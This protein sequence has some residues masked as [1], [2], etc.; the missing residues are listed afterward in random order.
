MRQ[1]TRARLGSPAARIAVAGTVIVLLV[2]GALGVTIWRFGASIN[3]YDQAITSVDT[4]TAVGATRTSAFDVSEAV[5]GDLIAPGDDPIA[6]A[7]EARSQ[8]IAHLD[9][10]DSSDAASTQ[11][12][13]AIASAKISAT[14]LD[15]EIRDLAAARGPSAARRTV[16]SIRSAL[17]A[18]D[19]QLD[20]ITAAEETQAAGARSSAHATGDS[21]RLVGIIVGALAVLAVMALVAYA[22]RLVTRLLTRIR[23]TSDGLAHASSE[24]RAATAVGAAATT[25]QSAAIAEVAVTLEEL[26]VS[27]A[28]IA[29]NARSTATEALETGQRSQQIGQVLELI[30]GVAEQTNLLALNA[31]IE[32]ARAGDAGRGFAVVASEVRTLAERTVRST[33]SIR[34][35]VTGI[36][37]KS[38]STI[39]A[40]EQSIA[41]TD[42]Q[43][44]AAEQAATTMVEIRRAAEQLAAEQRQ[45]AG[46][47][48][49]VETLVG[50]LEQLLEKYDT[51]NGHSPPAT[52]PAG[53]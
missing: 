23:G 42:Q 38:N 10:T 50:S 18:V 20:V 31:A 30:N 53:M 5:L 44:D 12:Q 37:E 28:A 45:R 17:N 3:R 14:S 29:E 43:K 41:A 34:E 52:A 8:L 39:L 26:S 36:Q 35:L 19:R 33:D 47:A 9:A 2:T 46:T 49:L 51:A 22:V 48:D 32:A 11:V 21:S 13:Q 4:I 40:T 6:D 15:G 25:E 16:A 1:I 27:A 7:Q 24:M